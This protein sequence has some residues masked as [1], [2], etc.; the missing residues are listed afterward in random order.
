MDNTLYC[1]K[2]GYMLREIAGESMAIPVGAD[3]PTQDLII[4]NPVSALLWK[5]LENEKTL[6]QL[7]DAVTK[8]FDADASDVTAD[9]LDFLNELKNLNILK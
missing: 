7:I 8:E 6:S 1:I 9:I 4:L 2:P 5:E 3:T